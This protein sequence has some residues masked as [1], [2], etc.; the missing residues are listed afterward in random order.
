VPK[1][2]SGA[3]GGPEAPAALGQGRERRR[4]P[5]AKAAGGSAA[6][7]VRAL[8]ARACGLVLG[9]GAVQVCLPVA[10]GTLRTQAPL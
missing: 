4:R 9:P 1:A 6:L 10:N 3:A 5:C 7:C 2:G 8:A